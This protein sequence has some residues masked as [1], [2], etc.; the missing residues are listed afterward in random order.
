MKK[1]KDRVMKERHFGYYPGDRA[2]KR[3]FVHKMKEIYAKYAV[4]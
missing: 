4:G 1:V 3:A 2:I